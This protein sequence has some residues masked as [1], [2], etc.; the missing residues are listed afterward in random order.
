MNIWKYVCDSAGGTGGGSGGRDE[1]NF[2][3]SGSHLKI[4]LYMKQGP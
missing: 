2:Q 1:Q 4:L 3:K